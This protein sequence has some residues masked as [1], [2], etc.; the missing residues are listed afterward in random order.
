M[1]EATCEER[2]VNDSVVRLQ[3]GD[4]TDLEI[5]AFVFYAEENLKLGS[6]F[7]TAISNRGGASIQK[8]LDEI[9]TLATC[10][11]VVTGAGKL[12]ASHIVHANGPKFQEEN[13]NEKLKT[14]IL[15]ALKKAEEKGI[16]RIAL[17]PMGAGFYGVPLDTCAEIMTETIQ[18]H[19][20]A[21][22]KIKEVTICVLDKREHGPFQSK[23]AAIN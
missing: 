19:L 8:E 10:E 22:S 6:G 21:G 13:T 14:T 11:S 2:K 23:M 7:G 3:I 18:E 15:N 1:A 5:D 4:I 12:K 17:P 20:K 9:G 16:E